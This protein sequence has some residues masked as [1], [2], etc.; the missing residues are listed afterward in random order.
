MWV[1]IGDGTAYFHLFSTDEAYWLLEG[2]TDFDYRSWNY[3]LSHLNLG[4]NSN[5]S[6][7][8]F[9]TLHHQAQSSLDLEELV[10]QFLEE[11]RLYIEKLERME[12]VARD[13]QDICN[14]ESHREETGTS[15]RISTF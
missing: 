11:T 2:M 1:E 3:P 5:S 14:C 12:T 9:D 15:G 6:V 8:W 10:A 13:T 7:P 4:D